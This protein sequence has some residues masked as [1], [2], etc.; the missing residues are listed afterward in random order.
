MTNLLE[1]QIEQVSYLKVVVGVLAKFH[2]DVTI[3]F[4]R[5]NSSNGLCTDDTSDTSDQSDDEVENDFPHKRKKTSAN[6]QNKK[7]KMNPL[8]TGYLKIKATDRSQSLLTSLKIDLQY[9]YCKSD[10]YDINLNM[11]QLYKV[12]KSHPSTDCVLTISVDADNEN[13][14][15]FKFNSPEF[16]Q[17]TTIKQV[18]MDKLT[19]TIPS[20][21]TFDAMMHIDGT[22]FRQL[23]YGMKN[24]SNTMHIKVTP[25]NAIF[26]CHNLEDNVTQTITFGSGNS[27]KIMFNDTTERNCSAEGT[28]ELRYLSLLASCE[29]LT[30]NLNIFLK[31]DFPLA[32]SVDNPEGRLVFAVAQVNSTLPST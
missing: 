19:I 26:T 31:N 23:C 1:V 21:I 25:D 8:N 32:L 14:V 28:F 5:D 13:S 18:E 29:V 17:S 27:L 10:S 7:T 30:N 2:N 9:F 20:P 11:S 16:S 15:T 22:K 4:V 24:V 12:L 6:T 3:E